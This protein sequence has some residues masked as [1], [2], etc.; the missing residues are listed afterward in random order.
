MSSSITEVAELDDAA[1]GF[2]DDLF[3]LD[4]DALGCNGGLFSFDDDLA[5][6]GGAFSFD[7]DLGF[8]GDGFS[9]DDDDDLGFDGGAFSLDDDDDLGFDGG[10]FPFDD[11]AF[12]LDGEACPS[13]EVPLLPP[14][15]TAATPR[16]ISGSQPLHT[17]SSSLKCNTSSMIA[18]PQSKCTCLLHPAQR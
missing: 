8:D 16:G 10:A 1:V 13:L 14:T 15:V 3:G 2:D 6:D 18:R 9:F 12:D 5:F 11:D 4:D 7:D 17:K